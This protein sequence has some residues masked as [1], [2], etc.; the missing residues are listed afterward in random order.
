M[1]QLSEFSLF[2]SF[3]YFAPQL[4]LGPQ[5][6]GLSP[7]D[8]SWDMRNQA[9]VKSARVDMWALVCFASCNEDPLRNFCHQVSGVSNR[10]GMTMTAQPALITFGRGPAEVRF[11]FCSIE[12]SVVLWWESFRSRGQ[13]DLLKVFSV[14]VFFFNLEVSRFFLIQLH[15]CTCEYCLM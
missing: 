9:V 6:K 5:D 12:G 1:Y 11:S 10:E 8:G 14:D 4:K 7:G 2:R 15:G 13:M 3:I